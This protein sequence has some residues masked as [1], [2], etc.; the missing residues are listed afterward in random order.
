MVEE[1]LHSG[2]FEGAAGDVFEYGL[3]LLGSDARKPLDE[4]VKR[5]DIFKVLEERG[6]RYARASKHPSPA[7]AAGVPFDSRTGRPVDHEQIV[8]PGA[9]CAASS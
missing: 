4:L 5:S 1:N 3:G 6:D 7:H 2:G 9:F 8:A